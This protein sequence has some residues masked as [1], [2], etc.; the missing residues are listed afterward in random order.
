MPE[1]AEPVVDERR[2]ALVAQ[3][4]SVTF[5][6]R[7]DRPRSMR[8]VL[9]GGLG[10]RSVRSVE[11]VKDVSLTI[12]EGESIGVI[13][14]NGSGKTTL[15]RTLAGLLPATS[16]TVH[17]RTRPSL[18]GIGIALKPALS[19]RRNIVL[20]G[21]ALGL[22]RRQVQERIDDIIDF[23]ELRDVID[24]PVKTYSSGMRSRLNFGIATSASR[25]ILLI[26][27]ALAVG[28]K[29]FR[30]KSEERIRGIQAESGTILLVSHGLGTIVTAC[31]RAIWLDKGVLMGDG[32]AREVVNAYRAWAPTAPPVRSDT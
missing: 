6:V 26:D 16:G 10:D 32:D 27:E 30:A 25:D 19:G 18:L 9:S 13:G 23:A 11:A 21:L 28:D 12:R 5:R 29:D 20:G 3:H 17:A 14:R 7:E 15:L 2:T 1:P 22:S 24:L 31:D 4:V 8:S